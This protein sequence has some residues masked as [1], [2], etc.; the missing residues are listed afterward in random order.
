MRS[1]LLLEAPVDQCIYMKDLAALYRALPWAPRFISTNPVIPSC[2]RAFETAFI[3][4][5]FLARCPFFCCFLVMMC[6]LTLTRSFLVMPLLVNTLVPFHT[7]RMDPVC[8]FF[9][10]FL[11]LRAFRT[12]FGALGL[13]AAR[14]AFLAALRVARRAARLAARGLVAALRAT[15]L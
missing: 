14:T 12:A 15:V 13:V 4:P 1:L 3:Q 5:V 11:A 8:I 10:T 6:P 2:L 7:W 9:V